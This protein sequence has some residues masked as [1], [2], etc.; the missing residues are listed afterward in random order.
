MV[1]KRRRKLPNY[2]DIENKFKRL[3]VVF[4]KACKISMNN[5]Y[6]NNFS[7]FNQDSSKC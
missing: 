5:Y 4:K 6:K 2:Y 1:L 3:S 7:A